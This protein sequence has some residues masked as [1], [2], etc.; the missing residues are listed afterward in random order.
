M[1]VSSYETMRLF[2]RSLLFGACAGAYYDVFRVL[3][4]ARKPR[5]NAWSR[6]RVLR[7]ADVALCFAGDLFFWLTLAAAYC[8]F[9]YD[10]ADGRLRIVSLIALLCGAAAWYFS[11]GRLIVLVADKVIGAVR[12]AFS[13]AVGITVIPLARVIKRLAGLL[14]RLIGRLFGAFYDKV[15]RRRELAGAEKGYGV[16][17]AVKKRRKEQ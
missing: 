2:A 9:I 12:T 17:H 16:F 4:I 3:R 15:E 7:Y 6:R 8:V 1:W 5:G 11:F 14:G 13:F 10:A